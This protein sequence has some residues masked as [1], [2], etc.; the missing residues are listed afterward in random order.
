MQELRSSSHEINSVDMEKLCERT[1]SL[2]CTQIT[3]TDCYCD[4]E[5]IS[6]INKIIEKYC[7]KYRF[8]SSTEHPCIHFFDNGNF[9]YMSKIW[10]DRINEPFS[11]IVFDHHPD[12]QE[13]RFGD[14]LSCGG[15]VKKVIT[16]NKFVQNI[17]IIGV[18]DRLASEILEENANEHYISKISIINESSFTNFNFAD[19]AFIESLASNIYISIDKDVL[20]T[21]YATTNW[22]QGSMS[23][24]KLKDI[25]AGIANKRKI[26]GIDICGERALDFSPRINGA[27]TVQE[28]D[29][30]N[31]R[32]NREL[33]EFFQQLL[34]FQGDF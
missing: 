31:N 12:M 32:L 2:D 24:A 17:I 7:G 28:A 20:S 14:I 4:E 10:T 27:K 22:D 16:E 15:W 19:S 33:V 1:I 30:M 29:E 9:H 18:H 3:G 21:D 11:L 5:A 6:E 26:I 25:I 34:S 23:T 8:I 13:P